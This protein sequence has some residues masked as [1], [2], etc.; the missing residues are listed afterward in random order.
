MASRLPL[1]K[2]KLQR[3]RVLRNVVPRPH[4]W[5]MLDRGSDKSLTL[6]CAGAGFGK[7]TLV[8]SWVE[9]TAT[10][11]PAGVPQP[12][13][14]LSLDENDSDPHVFLQYVVAALRTVAADACEE[15]LSLL[16]SP[17]QPRRELLFATLINEMVVLP[18]RIVLVLDDYSVIHSEI[19]DEFISKLV[20]IA[21]QQL[22]LVLITRRNPPLPLPQL[23]AADAITEIRSQD[24]RFSHDETTNY[25]SRS[26]ATPLGASQI[27]ALELRSEGW[28]AGLKLAVLSLRN[29]ASSAAV[30][31]EPVIG[32]ATIDE[33]LADEVLAQ[34]PPAVQSFLLRTSIVDHFCA[35]LCQAILAAEEPG[36]DART[37]IDWLVRS[38]LFVVSLAN[39]Q[40]WYRYHHLLL[41]MLRQRLAAQL[42]S[43]EVRELH[44]R[45]ATWFADQGLTNEALHH[46]MLAGDHD[47]A[48]QIMWA[49]LPDVLNHEDRPTLER[50]LSLLSLLPE[51]AIQ[52]RPEP[53][54]LKAWSLQF[55]WQL[56]AQADVLRQIES[57]LDGRNAAMGAGD[58]PGTEQDSR[59]QM[60]RAQL[61]V[62]RGQ[63]AFM[64]IA[65]NK[66]LPCCRKH[67]SCC[68]NPA[69]TCAVGQYYIWE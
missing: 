46:A 38:D 16:Q 34:Q 45:A 55:R 44:R 32:D 18:S 41:G 30:Q 29:N 14:W 35:S 19:I 21:P 33:Y 43:D 12:A 5:A 42:T 25:L 2:T 8:S 13:A 66:P 54:L 48:S 47:L 17:Q 1:L 26:L 58:A 36:W 40:D 49:A 4:L 15:T 9:H 23:R 52:G 53:L 65:Q 63:E 37:C 67:C 51:S 7:S 68:H 60:M 69:L 6:V 27:A 10:L 62:L 64:S 61:A 24:L 39:D 22:H 56:G 57:L 59:L 50:W 20:R 11:S 31:P 3:P 28:I